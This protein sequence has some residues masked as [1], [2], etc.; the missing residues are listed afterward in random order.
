M[1]YLMHMGYILQPFRP[2]SSPVPKRQSPVLQIEP[3]KPHDNSEEPL[4]S[5]RGKRVMS[6]PGGER[7]SPKVYII[8]CLTYCGYLITIIV[9]FR[10]S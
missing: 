8:M 5:V 3:T 9:F 10:I 4:L 6:A 7:K 2:K 1:H